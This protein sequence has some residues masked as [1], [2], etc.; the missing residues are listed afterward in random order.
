V[1]NG[2]ALHRRQEERSTGTLR[3]RAGYESLLA[4]LSDPNHEEHEEMPDWVG[5]GYNP[6]AYSAE[7]VAV[8]SY[9]GN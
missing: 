8:L 3:W 7:E 9:A 5:G 6:E 1:V 2:S 4:T